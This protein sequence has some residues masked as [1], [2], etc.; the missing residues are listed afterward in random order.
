MSLAVLIFS[1]GF[2]IYHCTLSAIQWHI[3]I[4]HPNMYISKRQCL[5][6]HS[7]VTIGNCITVC[8]FTI[9]NTSTVQCKEMYRD[10]SSYSLQQQSIYHTYDSPTCYYSS[11][12][13]ETT[14]PHPLNLA[15]IAV[16]E[17]AKGQII[18]EQICGVL[19]FSKKA[20][21]HCQDFC[22]TL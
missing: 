3:Q 16:L 2:G 21:K 19:K 22:P 4:V 12:I 7:S 17:S 10:V 18:S 1:E 9:T 15:R 14:P 20:T 11:S 5:D 13:L 6:L 8:V